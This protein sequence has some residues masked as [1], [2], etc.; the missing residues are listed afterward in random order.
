MCLRMFARCLQSR[1]GICAATTQ[2]RLVRFSRDEGFLD[3]QWSVCLHIEEGQEVAWIGSGVYG[4][5]SVLDVLV[6]HGA[7]HSDAEIGA[8]HGQDTSTTILV[9]CQSLPRA[10][11]RASIVKSPASAE[12]SSR[13]AALQDVRISSRRVCASETVKTFSF[14]GT[15]APFGYAACVSSRTSSSQ[16]CSH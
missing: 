12:L 14:L 2:H 7:R 11:S 1:A 6:R 3:R 4:V 8:L 16:M 10:F 15:M 5:E 9:R 13:T